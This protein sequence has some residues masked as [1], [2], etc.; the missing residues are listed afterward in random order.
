MPPA[1]AA[2]PW[3]P[4]RGAWL[5]V[6]LRVWCS[7]TSCVLYEGTQ[8]T[9]D[10]SRLCNPHTLR[11]VSAMRAAVARMR[12]RT[13]ALVQRGPAVTGQSAGTFVAVRSKE[14]A[15]AAD[16]LWVCRDEAERL[17]LVG[18]VAHMDAIR[19][20]AGTGIGGV[21]SV[22][23]VDSPLL[24]RRLEDLLLA[25]A[26]RDTRNEPFGRIGGCTGRMAR[27][28]RLPG[29]PRDAHLIGL[30]GHVTDLPELLEA[31][32]IYASPEA[33]VRRA[34]M[35]ALRVSP[36][37]RAPA[38]EVQL[39]HTFMDR[40][41]DEE[42]NQALATLQ[43]RVDAIL[44]RLTLRTGHH[45]SSG[46]SGADSGGLE[47]QALGLLMQLDPQL[48]TWGILAR[49]AGLFVPDDAAEWA[50][51]ED[52]YVA[53][54]TWLQDKASR[55]RSRSDGGGT[56]GRDW[57]TVWSD[58]WRQADKPCAQA[59]AMSL[60]VGRVRGWLTAARVYGLLS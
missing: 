55:K 34:L 58:V 3:D 4:S 10:H 54:G 33:P 26:L 40:G 9:R 18:L 24:L 45:R 43:R 30:I 19:N 22:V 15:E 48:R 25:S 20:A 16:T 50:V 31:A 23:L 47:R 36:T 8:A 60:A 37:F 51:S 35:H 11:N 2:T 17:G 14:A 53:A 27:T 12:A 21:P 42:R 38:V 49:H 32:L 46:S 39:C 1:A 44:Q 5:R 28:V 52:E 13:A 56:G 29:Q 7:P 41:T 59:K 57:R 6:A